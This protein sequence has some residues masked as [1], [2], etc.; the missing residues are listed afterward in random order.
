MKDNALIG[1]VGPC[2]AGKSTLVSGLRA[3]GYRAKHIAQEH[4][5]S[6]L[7]WQKITNPD[8][9][10]YLDVSYPVTIVRRSLDWNMS[11]YET[12]LSRLSV[13]RQKADL[14]IQTDELTIRQVQDIVLEFL[15]GQGID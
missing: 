11:E 9:L 13:A 6:P 12:Q 8:L 2:A 15:R 10:I 7:M 14:Y 1:I 3:H 4:S 5:Y